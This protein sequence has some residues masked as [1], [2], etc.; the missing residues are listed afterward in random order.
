M[1]DRESGD[2][3]QL[4]Q[5]IIWQSFSDRPAKKTNGLL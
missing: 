2:E 5:G 1:S 3:Q 4:A